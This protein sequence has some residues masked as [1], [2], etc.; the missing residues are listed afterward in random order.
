[1]NKVVAGFNKHYPRVFEA[2]V[3]MINKGKGIGTE[4]D[5]FIDA[6]AQELTAKANRDEG[7]HATVTPENIKAMINSE[8]Y[9][10]LILEAISDLLKEEGFADYEADPVAIKAALANEERDSWDKVPPAKVYRGQHSSMDKWN[11]LEQ[12]FP[13]VMSDLDP[14]ERSVFVSPEPSAAASYGL[15]AH[16][17]NREPTSDLPLNFADYVYE[18]LTEGLDPELWE[19]DES[20][21][22]GETLF[23]PQY[24]YK[25][26]IKQEMVTITDQAG[27]TRQVPRIQR[28]HYPS[29]GNLK[30]VYYPKHLINAV[31]R[32]F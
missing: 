20:G 21:S 3:R 26:P 6:E 16:F 11:P 24:R 13:G 17:D 25:G 18:I 10:N 28:V 30:N 8:A 2:L 12:G 22:V 27:N 9:E 32:R 29:D 1:M 31:N 15:K 4:G 23:A 14:D 5:E 7:E 19:P